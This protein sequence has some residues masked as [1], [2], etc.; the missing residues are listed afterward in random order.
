MLEKNSLKRQLLNKFMKSS[1]DAEQAWSSWLMI[2]GL[3]GTYL[4]AR[5]V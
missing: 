5:K 3:Q 1:R 4:P 2:D